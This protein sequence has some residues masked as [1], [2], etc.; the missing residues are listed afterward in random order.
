MTVSLFKN[1]KQTFYWWGHV[2]SLCVDD[3]L[4]EKFSWNDLFH[5]QNTQLSNHS[6]SVAC[7]LDD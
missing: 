2:T 5:F 1:I 6:V 7:M 4:R 3:D